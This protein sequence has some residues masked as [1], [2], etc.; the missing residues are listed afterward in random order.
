MTKER[1]VKH[2]I[3]CDEEGINSIYSQLFPNTEEISVTRVKS[4]ELSGSF[5]LPYVIKNFFSTDLSG[6][7]TSD[8]RNEQSSKVTIT[9]EDKVRSII[10]RLG[11]DETKKLDVWPE[12]SCFIVGNATIIEYDAL[13]KRVNNLFEQR[14]SRYS[15]FESFIEAIRSS[16][17]F[18]R[19]WS[20]FS[21]IA[22]YY[23]LFDSV[24]CMMKVLADSPARF[25]D[26]DINRSK[27]IKCMAVDLRYPVIL[28]FSTNKILISHSEFENAIMMDKLPETGILGI[29]NKADRNLYTLKPLAMWHDIAFKD[30]SKHFR[31][32]HTFDL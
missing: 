14:K 30:Y 13:E 4:R 18:E 5:A 31:G 26:I 28:S 8:V 3:Y 25:I 15:N 16:T 32:D 21:G 9:I 23:G 11:G 20:E 24:G 6:E 2:F 17:E 19:E 12:Q 10:K 29:L 27:V 22:S 7:Y 1:I